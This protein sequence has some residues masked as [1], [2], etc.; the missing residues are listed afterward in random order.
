MSEIE[1]MKTRNNSHAYT[2]YTVKI[3]NDPEFYEKEKKRV[4]L[5]QLKIFETD[6]EYWA[7]KCEY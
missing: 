1:D 6:E 4:L 3:H 5:Y 2:F 7:T